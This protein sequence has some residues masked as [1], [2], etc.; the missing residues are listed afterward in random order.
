MPVR[1]PSPPRLAALVLAAGLLLV[2]AAATALPDAPLRLLGPVAAHAVHLLA[3]FALGRAILRLPGAAPREALDVIVS[4]T[5]AG[6]GGLA[7]LTLAMSV[8]W[9]PA[10]WIPW[11]ADAAALAL[12]GV[13]GRLREAWERVSEPWRRRD[14]EVIVV[15]RLP[16]LLALGLVALLHAIPPFIPPTP[17]SGSAALALPM[18]AALRGDL[19]SACAAL[20]GEIFTP[21]RALLLHGYL[22]GGPAGALLFGATAVALLAAAAWMHAFRHL[23]DRAASWA[24]VLLLSAPMLLPASARDPRLPLVLLFAFLAF[25]E[26]ADWCQ[27]AS[28]G[29]IALASIFGGVL[30]AESPRGVA[31]FAAVLAFLFVVQALVERNGVMRQVAGVLGMSAIALLVALPLLALAASVAPGGPREIAERHLPQIGHVERDAATPEGA[32]AEPEDALALLGSW[33]RHALLLGPLVLGLLAALPLLPLPAEPV[34]HALLG[35]LLFGALALLPQPFGGGGA[36]VLAPAAVVA[37]GTA[38]ALL[39]R[40]GLVARATALF[41]LVAWPASI[42]LAL[43]TGPDVPLGAALVLGRSPASEYVARHAPDAALVALV[44]ERGVTPERSLLLVG[45]VTDAQYPWRCVRAPALGSGVRLEALAGGPERVELAAVDRL[46]AGEAA[47]RE[48][49]DR[50]VVAVT[51]D[52]R[53][54][55]VS[56]EPL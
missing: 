5:A 7:L 23:G 1:P 39:A 25:H 41:A 9:S 46:T 16:L 21:S 51:P 20:P 47:L 27:R 12:G 52:G 14:L 28:G 31:A 40:E 43:A 17:E 42:A 33:A 55:L 50:K 26:V 44:R 15:S 13:F 53:Y 35:A 10:W 24:A 30:V 6:L 32:G 8:A 19:A 37:A 4:S 29:K 18:Q 38:S 48:L 22:T 49:S 54:A 34:R 2:V 45:S 3:A 11:A 56:T 36:L